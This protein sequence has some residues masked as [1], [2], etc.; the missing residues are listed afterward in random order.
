LM[1][2]ANVVTTTGPKSELF[3]KEKKFLQ[4]LFDSVKKGQLSTFKK[5][6]E[7][8]QKD[9]AEEGLDSFKDAHGRTLVH[10]ACCFRQNEVLKHLLTYPIN[11]NIKD[12][13]K[14]QT[15]ISYLI[16][17]G[18]IEMVEYIFDNFPVDV[19]V[20]DKAGKSLLH[21]ALLAQG[22]TTEL[23]ELLL[24]HGAPVDKKDELGCP[25]L[26]A[27]LHKDLDLV[28]T[29]TAAGS[30]VNSENSFD[31]ATPLLMASSIGAEDIVEFLLQNGADVN[32]VNNECWNALHC[33]TDAGHLGIVKKLIEA[34]TSPNSLNDKGKTPLCMAGKNKQI[35][36]LLKDITTM[37]SAE[38]I[39]EARSAASPSAPADNA[40]KKRAQELKEQG[41]GFYVKKKYNEAI[42]KYTAAIELDPTDGVFF[43][44]RSACYVAIGDYNSALSDAKKC[45]ELRPDWSKSYYREAVA[46]ENLKNYGDA[47]ASY[48][49]AWNKEPKNKT[50]HASF[51]RCMEI[52]KQEHEAK[53]ANN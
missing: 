32:A 5:L 48:W 43:S 23:V 33:A 51:T 31:R 26:Y 24:K 19:T 14:G 49:E 22:K 9:V 29:L 47:A 50:L 18:D 21:D 34:G 46:Y 45:K 36:Q 35:T 27:V 30:D 38:Q 13:E 20:S 1:E 52:G 53:Q 10:F 37:P 25:L 8:R 41:N 28:K 15:A 2:G 4:S 17:N 44:N 39:E 6:L 11:I 16:R 40:E 7:R 12:E 42:E 3:L